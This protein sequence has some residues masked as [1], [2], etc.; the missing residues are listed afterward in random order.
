MSTRPKRKRNFNFQIAAECTPQNVRYVQLLEGSRRGMHL[1]RAHPEAGWMEAQR[2][3]TLLRLWCYLDECGHMKYHVGV[4][5][6]PSSRIEAE[7][8][9]YALEMFDKYAITV[10]FNRR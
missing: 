8:E 9:S 6:G 2:P 3:D 10:P 7:A 1:G 5:D 4:R